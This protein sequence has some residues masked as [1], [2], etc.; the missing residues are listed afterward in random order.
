M[1]GEVR[2]NLA[3]E[4]QPNVDYTVRI[5]GVEDRFGNACS[6]LYG[7][8]RR[9]VLAP[10]T[11]MYL[12]ADEYRSTHDVDADVLYQPFSYYVWLEP[13]GNGVFSVDY[14]LSGPETYV[15]IGIEM[16]PACVSGVLGDPWIGHTVELSVCEHDW[17]WIARIDCICI[18]PG[19]QEVVWIVPH[20]GEG[21]V[22]VASCLAGNPVEQVVATYPLLINAVYIGTML[23]SWDVSLSG[24]GIE[25]TWSILQAAG[26]PGFEVSRSSEGADMWQ[27][28]DSELIRG[29]GLNY[30]MLDIDVE[31]GL[32]YRYRVE[33]VEDDGRKILFETGPVAT[34][35]M[36]LTLRQNNPN[37]F[38]PSTRIEFL[39]PRP[40]HVR[41]EVF[42]VN[43]RL[44][45]V[46]ADGHLAS[47]G[48]SVDW[49]GRDRTGTMVSS[50]VYFYRLTA[51]KESLSRKMVLLR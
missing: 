41:I 15:P 20:P 19:E 7:S 44:I 10:S 18:D 25:L 30:S 37:P 23:E 11:K 29:D 35:A 26:S 40:G 36:P 17:L 13:G 50:G 48:H 47:G 45:R 38:N 51:G 27:N 32:S 14:S 34:P 1:T 31:F 6:G 33:C 4:P 39:L 22:Q 21:A 8:F 16:N 43:G 49:D 24:G 46:L 28:L 12:F 5:D 2:L 9:D 3:T 42:D